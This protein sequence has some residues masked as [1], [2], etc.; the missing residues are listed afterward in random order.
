M[1]WIILLLLPLTALLMGAVHPWMAAIMEL[2]AFALAGLWMARVS[3]G[4]MPLTLQDRRIRPLMLAVFALMAL[5]AFQLLPL[6]PSV[7]KMIAPASYQA[8]RTGLPGW[9]EH[10]A[11]SWLADRQTLRAQTTYALPTASE[12]HKGARVPFA[13][14]SPDE[15]SPE[16]LVQ[17]LSVA[18]GAW[19]PI[20]VAPRLTA[21]ALLKLMAYSAI[22]LLLIFYPF[23]TAQESRLYKGLVRTLLVT[24]LMVSLVGLSQPILS[25]GKPLWIFD[26][27]EFVGPHTW[28]NR[29]FGPFANPDHYADYLAMLWPFA[30]CGML[31]P[32][33][34]GEVKDKFAVPMLSATVGLLILA[35]LAATASRGGW[36]AAATGTLTVIALARRLPLTRR[37]ALFSPSHRG[38]RFIAICAIGLGVICLALL[39]TSNSSRSEAGT[40]LAAAFTHDSLWQRTAP[41]RDSG[42]M[43]AGS[44]LAGIGLGAW[45]EIYPRYASPPWSRL[46]MDAT[47]DEYVQFVAEVGLLGLLPV[48]I[49][50]WLTIRVIAPALIHLPS[51][52]FGQ[53]AACIAALTAIAVHSLI[54]FPLRVPANALLAAVLLAILTRL[55]SREVS[56]PSEVLGFAARGT[57]AVILGPIAAATFGVFTQPFVPYPFDLQR[58][59]SIQEA[60]TEVLRYP[61]NGRVHLELAQLLDDRTAS[62]P[63]RDEIAAALGLEP[64][65]PRAH[66]L[67]A[68]MLEIAGDRQ[69]ALDELQTSTFYAP[70]E[71]THGYLSERFLPRLTGDERAAIEKGLRRA[72]NRGDESA[73]VTLAHFYEMLGRYQDE[74]ELLSSLAARQTNSEGRRVRTLNRSGLAFA[75]AG[76]PHRAV[77]TFKQAISEDPA[78]PD[79]YRNLAIQVYGKADN[80]DQARQIVDQGVSNGAPAAPLYL[81][82]AGLASDRHD[83]QG[84]GKAL[85]Q[86]AAA[87]PSNFEVARRLGLLYFD[88]NNLDRATI[89]LRKAVQLNPDSAA[90]YFMLGQVEE[91]NYQYNA[92]DHDFARALSLDT[93]NARYR[94][95]YA[96]FRKKVADAGHL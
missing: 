10:A 24:G 34:L 82:L 81:A 44:P 13:P 42:A 89:W 47:H 49:A 20:S 91:F 90:T 23:T 6:P 96:N 65:N 69:D 7:L 29:V 66:D 30:L 86:A 79:A 33:V 68:L 3:L 55:C 54:D 11:Y 32:D 9:P 87:E 31:F 19:M 1:I 37:P 50:M 14:T 39:L 72:A 35:A 61:T 5:V 27:Y 80:L 67:K 18:P 76:N 43:I 63:K 64:S 45:P 73:Y 53:A 71:E 93:E 95:Y 58:P 41:A 78:N 15:L 83:P 62:G 85:E 56:Q 40:R 75:K 36:F 59:N 21:P 12:V 48:A 94:A 74:G 77:A 28:G 38:G 17:K 52:R 4:L 25:N 60:A 26:P 57:A 16:Q 8:Y 22:F 51:N 88:D 70:E 46:F 92:A 84:A 2:T